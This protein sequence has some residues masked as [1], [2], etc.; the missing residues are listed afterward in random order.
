[1]FEEE[2]KEFSFNKNKSK[3]NI[4]TNIDNLLLSPVEQKNKYI[5]E[6]NV[7]INGY[8]KT[9]DCSQKTKINEEK[10][11]KEKINQYNNEN[12]NNFLF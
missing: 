11:E 8:N 1:M 5:E 12:F 2:T 7:E 3:E 6:K 10:F 9:S 4:S